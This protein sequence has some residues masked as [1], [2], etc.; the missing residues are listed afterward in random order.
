MLALLADLDIEFTSDVGISR[1]IYEAALPEGSGEPS[2]DSLIDD[3]WIRVVW[4]RISVP[5]ELF[6]A[7]KSPPASTWTAF[8]TLLERRHDHVYRFGSSVRLRAD[9]T[10]TISAI[11]RGELA[12][13]DVG[14]QA[15][16][17]VAARLWEVL[18]AKYP[19]PGVA[20]RAWVDR[21]LLLG[22]PHLTPQ[23][24][25]A[26][27][28]LIA[29]REASLAVLGSEQCF[30]GWEETR[31]LFAKRI[32]RSHNQQ[33][34]NVERL[35]PLIPSSLVG[36][37][38]WLDDN[39]VQ[40][41]F[42]GELGTSE[43]L[44]GLT[45]LLLEDVRATEMSP[46]PN[47]LAVDLFRRAIARPELLFN[48]LHTVRAYPALVADLVL[49]PDTSPLA[50]LLIAQWQPLQ[51]GS[52]DRELSSRDDKTTIVM[53]FA[54]AVSA[55][56]H[57]LE[58]GTVQ[59]EEVAPLIVWVNNKSPSEAEDTSQEGNQLLSILRD[60]LVGHSPEI[61]KR[62]V[63][64]LTT[65]GSKAGL[66][67]PTFAAALDVVEL[68]NL[69]A[70]IDPV[71]LLEP[72]V[73]SVALGEYILSAHKVGIGA[74]AS[75]FDLAKRAPEE[76]RQKFLYPIDI[77]AR[78]AAGEAA[79]EN[80]YTVL[81]TLA[82]SLRA[83]IRVLSRAAANSAQSVDDDLSDALIAAVRAGALHHAEKGR[84]PA[85]A[86]GHEFGSSSF[87]PRSPNSR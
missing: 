58:Q 10:D 5:S 51:G 53:A 85:F 65:P 49:N 61:L 29:F 81:D 1:A 6:R 31:T 22:F 20:I 9:L 73:A 12:P 2:F 66:G 16:E 60:E 43:E 7:A 24:V 37:A 71:M 32:A 67:S 17:W 44:H 55:L 75:L 34:T 68:G 36:R 48:A 27:P 62:I 13:S 79:N 82:R 47:T 57:F 76:L 50:S 39:R 63:L 23:R 78:I 30:P 46:V 14:C 86:P 28:A 42:M 74:A 19:E 87:I 64:T 8:A 77:K 33:L 69:A 15:P 26:S 80:P 25:W 52:W 45:Q 40:N 59:P 18:L 21:W 72:Y 56:G 11:E 70:S 38:L 3:G 54:D 83:H 41:A 4:G 84:I 35:I